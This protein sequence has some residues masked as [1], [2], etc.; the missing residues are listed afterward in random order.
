MQNSGHNGTSGGAFYK[1]EDVVA[2]FVWRS[3]HTGVIL[4]KQIT[5][6]FYGR[7]HTK[8]YYLACSTGGRQGFK[9]V[10]DF[11]GDFDGVVAG[12]PAF[13]FDNLTSESGYFYTITGPPNSSTFVT[14]AMWQVIHQDVLK[15]CDKLDGYAD[16]IIED[17]LRCNYDPDDLLCSRPH[18]NES[19]CLTAEQALVV[20]K[21]YS[22]VLGPDG[23]V[24]YPRLE[25]GGEAQGVQ[26]LLNGAIFPYTQDWYR[27][28]I[29]N[30]PSWDPATLSAEDMAYASKLNPQDS[31]TWKGD[32]SKFRD[33]GSKV[34]HYH[35]QADGLI[36]ADNSPRYYEHVAETMK[37]APRELDDFYRFFRISGM[38]HCSGGPGA[39]EI[40][41]GPTSAP[42]KDPDANILTAIVRWV[43]EGVAPETV[44]GT[45]YVNDSAAS[46]V[47][48]KR[49]H[50]R[51][52][53]RNAYKGKGD[54]TEPESWE[55]VYG[56][57]YHTISAL[58]RWGHQWFA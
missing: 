56:E 4:G 40:G 27:Y 12:A 44:M 50:C 26:I 55:C 48:F 2:D 17:P 46:G 37:L 16:G 52:P 53:Y 7:P 25:P 38:Q 43:E 21:V 24:V 58:K 33:R 13:A 15:Q 30:D 19:A 10:Q 11:P 1:N 9:E 42:T 28:V 51:Y 32:L 6:S 47:S 8:S 22:P 36:S 31:Q 3:V 20:K 45:K 41:Q 29:Y 35:G 54:P 14:A 23:S 49:K 57:R 18:A 39:W 5:K 34:L